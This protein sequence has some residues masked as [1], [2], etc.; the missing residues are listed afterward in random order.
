MR[1]LAPKRDVGSKVDTYGSIGAEFIE[2]PAMR[3]KDVL[4]IL[5]K[6]G[7]K[8]HLNVREGD[9][10]VVIEG[11][12]RMKIGKVQKVD[13]QKAE[14]TC[15]GLNMVCHPSPNHS[16]HLESCICSN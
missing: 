7:G 11:P 16:P 2:T 5:D 10:V 4:E 3:R 13:K 12:D 1:G 9:R 6:W 14:V 8:K 15:E